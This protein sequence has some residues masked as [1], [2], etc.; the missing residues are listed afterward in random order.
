MPW[1]AFSMDCKVF[2]VSFVVVTRFVYVVSECRVL[3]VPNILLVPVSLP[4]HNRS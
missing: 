1:H 2:E 4:E 3:T